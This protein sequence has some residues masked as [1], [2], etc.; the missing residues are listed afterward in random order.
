MENKNVIIRAILILVSLG[1]FSQV[2]TQS[3]YGDFP[4]YQSF[5]TSSRPVEIEI[6]VVS[7]GTNSA[8]FTLDGLR[9]TPATTEQFGGVFIEDRKFQSIQGIRIEFE[10][11]MYGGTLYDGSYGDGMS[12]FFFDANVATPKI[13]AKGAGLGYGYNRTNAST[14]NTG[15]RCSG[16]SGAYLGVALDLFGNFKSRRWQGDSRV[17]GIPNISQNSSVTL[18]GARGGT[19]QT[20]VLPFQMN[21]EG[22]SGYP[23]LIAQGTNA[24]AGW[25]L[26]D[27]NGS[28]TNISSG[29][30]GTNLFTLGGTLSSP[31]KAIIELFPNTG[32]GGGFLVTVKIQHNGIVT[33]VIDNYAYKKLVPYAENAYS[34]DYPDGS[35]SGPTNPAIT[36]TVTTLDAT[37]PPYLKIGFAASTGAATNIH[38]LKELRITL[39]GSAEAY[40]DYASTPKGISVTIDALANDI[41]Y[42]GT[43]SQSMVGSANYLDPSTFRFCNESGVDIGGTDAGGTSYSTAEGAWLFDFTTGKLTFTPAGS[44]IG[45]AAVKYNIK[46]GKDDEAPYSDDAYRSL[47]ATVTV[48]VVPPKAVI[49]NRMVTPVITPR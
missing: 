5:R 41:G 34:T 19:N 43:I 38:I 17:N 23:V 10:Y 26:H 8:A 42:T 30:S 16:L 36:S 12:V 11:A 32:S 6:P 1:M 33:T 46:A 40:D 2:K 28:Y 4:Y 14:S 44:F 27:T 18:R 48:D 15:K 3:I 31:Q 29:H 39:P 25:K 21:E 9:L 20:S 35:S 47:P 37:I 45:Q 22:F 7:S 49:S 24:T 13:G